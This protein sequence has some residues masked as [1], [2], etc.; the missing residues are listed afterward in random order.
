[1]I[2]FFIKST[3][4]LIVLYSFYHIFLRQQKILLFNR[5]YLIFSLVF[6]MIIPQIAIPVKSSFPINNILERFTLTTGKLIQGGAVIENSPSIFTFQNILAN[7]FIIISSIL[8]IRFALNIF[9][10]SRKILISK[11]VDHSK[12]SIV[13]VEERTLP[14]SFFRYIFVNQSDYENGKIEKELLVHEEAHCQQYHSIDII[15]IELLNVFLWFNP[16]IWL[17]RKSILLNH[18]YYADSK[19][20]NYRDPIDYQQLLL[21]IILRN[22]TNYLVS[23]FKYSFIKSR[24]NMMTKSNPLHNS[25]LRKFS[26]IS[27]FLIMAITLTF[28]QEIKK[29]DTGMNFKNEWWTPILKKHNIIPSGFNNFGKVFEMG[30]TNSIDGRIVTLENAVFVITDSGKYTIIKT[31]LAIHDLDKNIIKGDKEVTIDVY[32]YNL[33]DSKPLHAYS[34]SGFTYHLKEG[35]NEGDFKKEQG[36]AEIKPSK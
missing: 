28:S 23:N 1:M 21:N 17:F 9:R 5:F 26:A 2:I 27:L 4:C 14:Y 31:P 33:E 36:K 11:R 13:F 8:L 20:L 6:S 3:A 29:I 32:T 10:I 25:I 30:T 19:V 15:I 35:R 24:I 34:A 22:N 7:L 16:A 18:E 12:T